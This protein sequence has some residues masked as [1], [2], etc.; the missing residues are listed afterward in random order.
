MPEIPTRPLGRTD[1]QLT[2]LSLGAAFIGGRDDPSLD[3]P[4]M[5][6]ERFDDI[7]V[8]T[9]QR[10][11]TLG[12]R[13][14]D[15]SPLYGP[16]ERR[17]GMTLD[18]DET[19]GVTISTKVGT[20]PDRPY[21]YTA[22]DIRWSLERSLALLERDRV[23]IVLIHDPASMDPVFR[24]GDGFDALDELRAEGLLDYVGLGVRDLEFHR[25]AIKSGRVDVIL[26]YADYNLVRRNG[27]PAHRRGV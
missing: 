22:E 18:S 8:D 27:A 4:D 2:E 23:E 17:I 15:T 3:D 13:H 21:S 12:V 1:L 7:A 16:S 11:L 24:A 20:H 14:I 19:Q 25:T 10:A 26:T 6:S 9:V 5:A